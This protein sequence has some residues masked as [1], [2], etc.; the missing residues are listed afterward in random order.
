[1]RFLLPENQ[2]EILSAIAA[3]KPRPE[4]TGWVQ[5]RT[6]HVV[7]LLRKYSWSKDCV[8][9]IADIIEE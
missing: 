3:G 6:N 2:D 5:A 9:Y 7:E 4:E 1:M 8:N